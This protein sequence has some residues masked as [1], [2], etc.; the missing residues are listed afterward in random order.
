MIKKVRS[1]LHEVKLQSLIFSILNSPAFLNL[2]G[3]DIFSDACLASGFQKILN[4]I[5]RSKIKNEYI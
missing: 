3:N 2:A 5:H 4:E 1:I